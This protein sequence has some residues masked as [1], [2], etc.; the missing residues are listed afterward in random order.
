MPSVQVG[1]DVRGDGSIDA[2][3]GRIRRSALE[4]RSGEDA[5]TALR[6]ALAG[7]L[8]AAGEEIRP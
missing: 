6:R 3:R 2:F 7:V 4:R 8:A 5:F 1:V